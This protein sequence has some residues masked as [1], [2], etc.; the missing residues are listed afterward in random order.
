MFRLSEQQKG[1]NMGTA[2]FPLNAVLCPGGRLPLRIFEARYLDM[3]ARCLREGEGF[4][5]V[6]MKPDTNET[7]ENP[8]YQKGT[9]AKIVDFDSG[10]DGLLNITVEGIESAVIKRAHRDDTGLWVGDI[11]FEGETKVSYEAVPVPNQFEELAQIL[12]ALVRHPSVSDLN[13]SIDF[14]DSRQVGL[15][16]T[17][18]LPLDNTQKQYLF[19][20][21]DPIFRLEKIS[22]QLSTLAP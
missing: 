15:R 4:V 11:E 22:D 21:D 10:D 6:L 16:L 14:D 17:E 5:V 2:L 9:M 20:L 3:I 12:K 1:S 18:L 13:L 8:F 7:V 19:E